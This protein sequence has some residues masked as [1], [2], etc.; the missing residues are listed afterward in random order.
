MPSRQF[1]LSH[2]MI[3]GIILTILTLLGWRLWF[4]Q[5]AAPLYTWSAAE[6]QMLRSLWI[7]SLPPPPP[8]PS[9]AYADNSQAVRL[10]AQFFFDARFSVGNRVSCSTCHLPTHKF[11]DRQQVS[12][13]IGQM[14]RNAQ[15]IVGVAY[16]PWFFWDGR[17]DSLWSQALGPLEATVEHGG[18]RTM[19]AHI[20]AQHYREE[21]EALFGP[22]PADFSDRSRFPPR[23]GPIQASTVRAAWEAMSAADQD[24][25][26][27]VFVNMGKAIAAFERR[28]QPLPARF[29]TYVEAVLTDDAQAMQHTLTREEIDGLRLFIGKARCITCHSGPLFTDNQFY[30]IGVPPAAGILPD[31]GRAQ[32]VAE[33]LQDEF[34]CLSRWSDADETACTHLTGL[35]ADNEELVGAFRTPT[36]RNVADTAPYMHAGQM[37]TLHE[38]LAFFNAGIPQHPPLQLS[39]TELRHLEAFLRTLSSP[40]AEPEH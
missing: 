9:N 39:P 19:Y 3:I 28:V 16:H 8:A 22:L 17:K 38:T 34:T 5:P 35:S 2:V 20:I 24:A 27:E 14:T 23:A 40:V 13:G 37:Q 11:T 25:V 33:L 15:T 6:K 31:P 4:S 7:E 1:K 10:G 12:D 30:A 21:Y 29:D 26:T 32:G 18:D 36:L